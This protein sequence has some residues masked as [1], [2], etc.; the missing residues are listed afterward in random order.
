MPSTNATHCRHRPQ[1][2][3]YTERAARAAPM[4]PPFDGAFNDT[5]LPPPLPHLR[6]PVGFTAHIAAF[7]FDGFALFAL[8]FAGGLVY[9][10]ASEIVPAVRFVPDFAIVLCEAA[11]V[12]LCTIGDVLFE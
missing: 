2:L 11:G 10:L 8:A 6:R 3:G 1:A 12:V 7:F 5:S 4:D 9:A